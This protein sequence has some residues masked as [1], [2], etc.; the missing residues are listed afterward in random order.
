MIVCVPRH[1]GIDVIEKA[2]ELATAGSDSEF[3]GPEPAVGI[4]ST[5]TRLLIWDLVKT[6]TIKTELTQPGSDN[7][8]FI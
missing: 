2:D 6:N 1:T 3:I 4:S 7:R 5:I 8:K